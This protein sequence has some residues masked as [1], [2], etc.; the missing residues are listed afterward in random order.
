MPRREI[1]DAAASRNPQGVLA[2][3]ASSFGYVDVDEILAHASA[4]REP[5]LLVALDGVTDPQNLGA[6]AR[7]AEAAGAHGIVIPSRRSASITAAAE[8]ASAGALEHLAVA[9]VT[10]L[11]RT[12]EALK[13]RGVWI[14][15]LVA[16]ADET[17]YSVDVS[18]PVCLV[19]GS[20]GR[21]VS[22][23]VAETSDHKASIPLKGDISSLNASAAAAIALFEVAR[24]RSEKKDS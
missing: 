1:D 9:Q 10:N 16:D 17:I 4:S 8:K 24:R 11:A 7:S 6:I 14:V 21:G 20:E 3:A 19:V 5:A 2:Y 18:T 13:Q 12:L 23:L 15:A 22:R